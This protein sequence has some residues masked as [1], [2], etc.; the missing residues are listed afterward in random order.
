MMQS[1]ATLLHWSDT[2]EELG[3][4]QFRESRSSE[5]EN[6]TIDEERGGGGGSEADRTS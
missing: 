6:E 2:N 5:R 3:E 1:A 4:G